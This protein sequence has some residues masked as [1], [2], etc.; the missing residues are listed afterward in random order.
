MIIE[1]SLYLTKEKE[2]V[3]EGDVMGTGKKTTLLQNALLIPM[4]TSL[5]SLSQ[6]PQSTCAFVSS[7]FPSAVSVSVSVSETPTS[8][9]V[10]SLLCM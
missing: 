6:Q 3:G 8:S 9:C 4:T 7:S 10:R 1:K 5:N 2:S